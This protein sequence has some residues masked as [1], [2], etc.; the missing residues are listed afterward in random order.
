M[1]F[2]STGTTQVLGPQTKSAVT[3]PTPTATGMTPLA[4]Y[5]GPTQLFFTC[6]TSEEKLG[7]AWE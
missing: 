2:Q 4:S 1:Y 6:S 3:V 7:G 5:P